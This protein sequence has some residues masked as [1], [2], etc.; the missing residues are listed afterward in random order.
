MAHI[1]RFY[2]PGCADLTFVDL[3]DD[4]LH[5]ALHVLRVK[6]GDPVVLFDGCGI[7]CE[8]VVDTVSR[9]SVVVRVESARNADPPDHRLTI[10]LAWL[11]RG[12]AIVDAIRRGTELGVDRFALFESGHSEAGPRNIDKLLRAAVE[13]CKQCERLWLP[14]VVAA[15]SLAEALDTGDEILMARARDSTAM[16]PELSPGSLTVVIGPEGGLT[17][18]E[19]SAAL[20]AGARPVSLGPHVLRAEVA[21]AAA[22][23]IYRRALDAG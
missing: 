15:D 17:E 9:R 2:V 21:V 7:E 16:L 10:V 5:H 13:G 18:G 22:A 23:A 14:E 19:E 12:N 3:P 6:P 8:G 1:P 11:G 4:E 20:K